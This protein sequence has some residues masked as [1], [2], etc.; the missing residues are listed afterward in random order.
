MLDMKGDELLRKIH[1]ISPKTLKIMLTGQADMEA[2]TSAVNQAN[3]YRYIA[4]PWERTDLILTVK[5]AIQKYIQTQK[6][7]EQNVILQNMNH[8][9]EEQVEERTAE[10]EA[11]KVE[12]KQKN[13]Q[14]REVNANKDKFFSIISHDL[15]A[16]FTTLLGFANLLKENA[17]SYS[18]EEVVHRATKIYGSADRLHTLLENLLMWSQ[19]QRGVMEYS[20]EFILLHSL[21]YETTE[22]FRPNAEEKDITLTLD[23]PEQL[24]AYGDYSMVNSVLRNLTSNALKFTSNGGEVKLWARG[25]GHTVEVRVIDTGVGIPEEHVPLLFRIDTQYTNPGTLGERGTG[26]GLSLCR[27]LVEKNHGMIW[28][29]SELGKG[30]TFR[31][32]LPCSPI[33]EYASS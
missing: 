3:L 28:V 11:Q 10:L 5:E 21:T 31:F 8:I 33:E 15:R 20:P 1:N 30:T 13:A 18:T 9:L 27:E 6:L 14:L 16:P 26:L 12:L 23:I 17:A 22:L 29:E 32:T 24:S 2:V 19:L 7:E 25:N 4:K